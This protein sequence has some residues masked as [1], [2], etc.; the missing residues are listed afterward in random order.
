M[1]SIINPYAKAVLCGVELPT[2]F[3]RSA[4]HEGMADENGS[5]D[6][7]L[8]KTYERYAKGGVGLIITGYMGVS[9][10]GKCPLYNMTMLNDDSLIAPWKELTDRVHAAGAPI[11][12]QIAHSGRQTRK[13]ITGG[14]NG[15]TLR[16]P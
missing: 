15:R 13:K 16:H 12:A 11:F 7:K 3:I 8:I 5:P 4:T 14:E 1:N 2:R 10:Q 6:E 9:Q